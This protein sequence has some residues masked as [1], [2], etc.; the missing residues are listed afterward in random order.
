LGRYGE[1][2]RTTENPISLATRQQAVRKSSEKFAN[3]KN[4]PILPRISAVDGAYLALF[5]SFGAKD[6]GVSWHGMTDRE[7]LETLHREMHRIETTL[8]ALLCDLDATWNGMKE[9]RSELGKIN[10]E[11]ATLRSL[12]PNRYTRAG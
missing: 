8:S 10:K 4:T 6:M 12:W 2:V 9:T 1:T 7:K 5:R 3:C 11:V